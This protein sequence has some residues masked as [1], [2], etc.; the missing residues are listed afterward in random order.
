MRAKARQ[1]G[2]TVLT[3]RMEV[4][5]AEALALRA[6]FDYWRDCGRR[7]VSEHVSFY[8]DGACGFRPECVTRTP[9]VRRLTAALRDAALLNIKKDLTVFGTIAVAS[10]LLREEAEGEREEAADLPGVLVGAG[11]G[12]E[13]EEE[14]DDEADGCGGKQEGAVGERH[15]GAVP[16]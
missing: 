12:A 4:S 13:G 15:A 8:V 5:E 3:V 7:H 9:G 6:M 14:G 16:G 10:D 11:E 1:P 2:K